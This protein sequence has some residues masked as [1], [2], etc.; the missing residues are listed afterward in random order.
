M[1]LSTGVKKAYSGMIQNLKH[2]H[3]TFTFTC[4]EKNA[5]ASKYN[6][7]ISDAYFGHRSDGFFLQILVKARGTGFVEFSILYLHCLAMKLSNEKGIFTMCL[8]VKLLPT[9]KSNV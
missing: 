7:V 3:L 5:Y 2:Q 8:W 6:F 1:L 9:E 4:F